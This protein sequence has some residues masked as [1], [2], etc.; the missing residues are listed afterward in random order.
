MP[1]LCASTGTG[2]LRP[3]PGERDSGTVTGAGTETLECPP[4]CVWQVGVQLGAIH[5]VNIEHHVAS[6]SR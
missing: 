3:P 2:A 5:A 1:P 4:T 6:R